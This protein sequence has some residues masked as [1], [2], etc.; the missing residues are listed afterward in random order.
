[1]AREDS[2]GVSLVSVIQRHSAFAVL[3]LAYL[4]LH[5]WDVSPSRFQARG[6]SAEPASVTRAI[7][8]SGLGLLVVAQLVL[9]ARAG[10]MQAGASM[11]VSRYRRVH[12]FTGLLVTLFLVLHLWDVRGAFLGESHEVTA[13]YVRDALAEP[14]RLTAYLGGITGLA[15][16]LAYGLRAF[17]LRYIARSREARPALLIGGLI[18]AWVFWSGVDAIAFHATG[19]N[20]ARWLGFA[21]G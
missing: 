14:L 10:L 8:H 19:S 13:W 3:V 7:L 12:I 9:G 16:H 2:A 18:A 5:L 1:M 20:L 17:V 4:V 6:V 15:V 21:A 11:S